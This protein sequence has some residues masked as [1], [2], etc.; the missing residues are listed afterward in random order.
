MCTFE[1]IYDLQT[2]YLPLLISASGASAVGQLG[3]VRVGLI[4]GLDRDSG[5]KLILRRGVI[6]DL[7][8]KYFRAKFACVFILN[9]KKRTFVRANAPSL[10]GSV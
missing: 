10:R 2:I 4:G 3:E 9:R 5:L 8:K 1:S 6:R 7:K